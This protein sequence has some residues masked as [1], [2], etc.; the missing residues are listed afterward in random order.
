MG[1]CDRFA[2]QTPGAYE[3][4]AAAGRRSPSCPLCQAV[5]GRLFSCDAAVV[6][7]GKEVGKE[8][9]SVPIYLLVFGIIFI[10]W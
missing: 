6:G 4:P 2:P 1:R 8:L 5:L 10:L 3:A 7:D 9:L